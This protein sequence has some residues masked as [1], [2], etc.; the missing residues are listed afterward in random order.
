MTFQRLFRKH[1]IRQLRRYP[2]GFRRL[3]TLVPVVTG[4]L[5]ASIRLRDTGSG[6]LY[7]VAVDYLF[8]NRS[9]IRAVNKWKPHLRIVIAEAA[10]QAFVCLLYTSPSPRD[11]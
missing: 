3:R 8:F 1:L 9:T 6:P 2:S 7:V 11:S 5:R 10:H 4:R